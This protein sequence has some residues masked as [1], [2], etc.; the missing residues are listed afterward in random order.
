MKALRGMT[1]VEVLA[2]LVI[3]S[4]TV[5]AAFTLTAGTTDAVH[6]AE[7][8]RQAWAH[9]S[10]TDIK[11]AVE[12]GRY[13][14]EDPSVGWRVDIEVLDEVA[15]SDTPAPVWYRVSVTHLRSGTWTEVLSQ[16]RVFEEVTVP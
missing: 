13:I 2:A 8:Q 7:L 11:G 6:H 10:E 4:A 9:L 1:L 3:L 12:D 14:I 16:L 15:P 5:T